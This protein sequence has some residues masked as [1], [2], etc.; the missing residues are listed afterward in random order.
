MPMNEELL[1]VR[2]SPG[3]G[4]PYGTFTEGMPIAEALELI[5]GFQV[6]AKNGGRVRRYGRVM[7]VQDE[8]LTIDNEEPS[9]EQV[10]RTIIH[11]I[12]GPDLV[13]VW[14]NTAVAVAEIAIPM[15]EENDGD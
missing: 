11:F 9:D 3:D 1:K 13:I 15:G 14:A 8:L 6:D 4:Q 12:Q 7:G 2:L 5:V 10:V